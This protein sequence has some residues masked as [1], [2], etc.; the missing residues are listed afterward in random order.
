LINTLSPADNATDIFGADNLVAT[1]NKPVQAGTGSIVLKRSDD[2]STV[3][4]FDVTTDVVFNGSEIT[5]DPASTL[6]PGTGYYVTINATAVEDLSGNAFDGL[7]GNTAW[8]FTTVE[9]NA[10]IP[11]NTGSGIVASSVVN[12][13]VSFSF[14]AGADADML[15]VA[16]STEHSSEAIPTLS[17]GGH[18]LTLAIE[19]MQAGIWY[20]DL[21]AVHYQGGAAPLVIDFTG[22]NKVNGVAMGAVSVRAQGRNIELHATALGTTSADLLTTR[23]DA[24]VL[25]S[26]NANTSGSPSV[27]APLTTIY[28]SGNIGSAQG[29][30]GYEASVAAGNHPINWTTGNKRRVAVAAFVVIDRFADWIVDYDLGTATGLSDDPDGDR[31]LNGIEAWFGSNPGEFSPSLVNLALVG[32]NL[33][34]THPVSSSMLD[35]LEGFYQ[36]SM[37]LVDWYACD[38]LEGPVTGESVSLSSQVDI[39][40]VT[41]TLSPSESMPKLFVRA[42]VRVVE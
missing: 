33:T 31:L 27:D 15:M 8:S 22:I 40:V 41:V 14:D 42:A 34:F 26:F 5:I 37:N 13:S 2:D 36:W 24:F 20:L 29:A 6:E 1:F 28:A 11:V 21:T 18:A 35:D 12:P 38:G 3:E 39:G 9:A 32:P 30:A 25:A 7:S 23:S 17:Y 16:V 10:I 19:E 4:T